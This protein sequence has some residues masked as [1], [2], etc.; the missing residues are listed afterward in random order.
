MHLEVESPSFRILKETKLDESE[1]AKLRFEQLNLINEKRLS[2]I[3]HYCY[4]FLDLTCWKRCIPLLK[5][6]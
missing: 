1:W 3:C 4:S 2:A 6:V 5:Q